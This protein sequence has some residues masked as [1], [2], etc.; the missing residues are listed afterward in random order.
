MSDENCLVSTDL[1]EF[2]ESLATF[3]YISLK[4]HNYFSIVTNSNAL[5]LW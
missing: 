1:N 3:L 4:M 5:G 2:S